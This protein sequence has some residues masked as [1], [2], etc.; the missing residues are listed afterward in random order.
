MSDFVLLLAEMPEFVQILWKVIL[1]LI[2]IHLTVPEE[3]L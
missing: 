2:F 3:T 1:P